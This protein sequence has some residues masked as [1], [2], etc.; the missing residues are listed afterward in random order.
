LNCLYRIGGVDRAPLLRVTLLFTYDGG[1]LVQREAQR[2]SMKPP[3]LSRKQV[4]EAL[5]TVPVSLLLGKEVNRELTPK[6][7]RFALEVAKGAKGAEAYRTVYSPNAKP[8]T[9]GDAASRMKRDSRI[10]AE[11]DAIEAAIRAAEYETPAGLRSLVIHSLVKVITDPESKPGQIT[12]AA[13][14]LGSVTEVAAFT[15]RKEIRTIRS[16][17][18][19]RAQ[20]MAQLREMLKAQ[21]DDAEV[22]DNAADSLLAEL[23][24]SRGEVDPTHTPPPDASDMVG[25]PPTHTIPLERSPH[26]LDLEDTPPSF[27]SGTPDPTPSFL[28]DPPSK[29]DLPKNEAHTSN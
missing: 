8:K 29:L 14:V 25:P 28:G 15:E 1:G 24:G 13:K 12:A 19:T 20:V 21:A 18:D 11:I 7:R 10:A 4:K 23:S 6:Q 17:E 26:P 9:A 16:S 27:S 5:D 2:L 3:K 22:I